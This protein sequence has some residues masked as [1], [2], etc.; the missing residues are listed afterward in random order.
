MS[1]EVRKYKIK[2]C[3]VPEE[4]TRARV[5]GS[6]VRGLLFPLPQAYVTARRSKREV[7]RRRWDGTHGF[8]DGGDDL[9]R[10]EVG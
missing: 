5:M 2:P 9:S 1:S 7:S 10:A 6:G 8:A 3:D 4:G